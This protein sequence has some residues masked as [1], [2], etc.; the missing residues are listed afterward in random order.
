[1][2]KRILALSLS[3]VLLLA[4]LCAC[5]GPGAQDTSGPSGNPTGDPAGNPT[6]NPPA[7][8]DLNTL[9]DDIL[10][11][12]GLSEMAFMDIPDDSLADFYGI[13]PA[14]LE[15][16]VVK[17]PMMNVQATE[18]FMAKVKGGKMD[19]VKAA[20]ETRQQNL[21]AQWST[22]LPD[23]YKLVQDYELVTSGDYV[24]FAI[25]DYAGQAVQLFN[26]AVSGANS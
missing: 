10:A 9:W 17:V 12:G 8:I 20:L 26:D 25:S 13:D 3:A 24:L 4:L 1:M 5:G 21:D 22:Y 15:T 18:F 19:T 7:D 14:D 6:E 11:L 23:Q 2:K 16:Y